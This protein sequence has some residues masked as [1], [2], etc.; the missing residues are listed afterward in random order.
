MCVLL[1]LAGAIIAA[2]SKTDQ[3]F[4]H[5]FPSGLC[6]LLIKTLQGLELVFFY[7]RE[8]KTQRVS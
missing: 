3:H 4:F 6:P 1:P 5:Q 2:H 8:P 7:H